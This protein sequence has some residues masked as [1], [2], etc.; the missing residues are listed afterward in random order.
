M[1][2]DPFEVFGSVLEIQPIELAGLVVEVV[3]GFA[4]HIVHMLGC[5]HR[6]SW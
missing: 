1:Y 3:A 5:G 2:S 6:P 4:A